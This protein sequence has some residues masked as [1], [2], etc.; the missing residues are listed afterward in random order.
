MSNA[1]IKGFCFHFKNTLGKSFGL[2]ESSLLI[3]V[4]LKC[5][6]KII[7]GNTEY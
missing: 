2:M 4:F 1:G 6:K 5:D 3:D 7:M